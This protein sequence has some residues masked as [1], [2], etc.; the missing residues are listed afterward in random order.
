MLLQIVMSAGPLAGIRVLD[1]TIFQA[2]PSATRRLADYGAECL[3]L[4][5]PE[6]GDPGRRVSV[7]DGYPMFFNVFNRNKGSVVL[8]L[9]VS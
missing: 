7:I 5:R 1:L 2:G 3:K 8:D 6:T 9:K 4:E